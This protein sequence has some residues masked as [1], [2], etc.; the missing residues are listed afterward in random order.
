MNLDCSA[1]I[2]GLSR[3]D[4]EG[5]VPDAA[6]GVLQDIHWSAGLMGYF[7]TYSLG[8]IISCQIWEKAN[9]A[10]PDLDGQFERGEFMPLREW[11][12]DN[13]HQY[14]RKF[15]PVEML[16]RLTGSNIEVGPYVRYLYT[17]LRDIYQIDDPR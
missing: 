9:A 1:Y 3:T 17:K 13:L 14:G 5:A 2:D 11:L 8:N 6:Q 7:P 15:T 16:K 4:A 12:R 10:Q